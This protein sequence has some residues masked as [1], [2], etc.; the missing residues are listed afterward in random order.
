MNFKLFFTYSKH[1]KK[2]PVQN[3]KQN[4]VFYEEN[5]IKPKSCIKIVYIELGLDCQSLRKIV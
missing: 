3:L 1:Y 5:I 2:L 4:A